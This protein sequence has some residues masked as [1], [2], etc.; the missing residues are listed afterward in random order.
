MDRIHDSANQRSSSCAHSDGRGRRAMG[1]SHRTDARWV[2]VVPYRVDSLCPLEPD[3]IPPLPFPARAIKRAWRVSTS[4]RCCYMLAHCVEAALELSQWRSAAP[5][6]RCA[7]SDHL[8]LI[9]LPTMPILSTCRMSIG[10]ATTH[11]ICKTALLASLTFRLICVPHCT[12]S[13]NAMHP[14]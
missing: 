11:Y 10:A 13:L 3:T 6:R 12:L 8:A 7:M 2:S 9:Q 14:G 4:L 1:R 5:R